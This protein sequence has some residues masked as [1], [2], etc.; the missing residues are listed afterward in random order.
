MV[1]DAGRAILKDPDMFQRFRAP[2]EGTPLPEAGLAPEDQLIVF[3]RGG[4]RRA[5]EL[6]RMAYHHLA[7][8]ELAGKPYLISF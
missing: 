6:H 1:F 2:A 4:E 7:Q 3:E 5:L 8:G